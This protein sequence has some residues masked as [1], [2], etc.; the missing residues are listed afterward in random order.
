MLTTVLM[1]VVV[2]VALL[3]ASGVQT[4]KLV[5]RTTRSLAPPPMPGS[6]RSSDRPW[7]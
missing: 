3:A 5:I 4:A 6:P 7:T 2:L 1:V